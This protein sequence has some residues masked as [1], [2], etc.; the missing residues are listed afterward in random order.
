[1]H[2]PTPLMLQIQPGDA[3]PLGRQIVDGVRRQIAAGELPVG[4]QLPSV[5]V[6]AQQLLINPNTVAKAYA[7][8]CSEGWL[9]SQPGLGLFVAAPR[10]RLS[11]AEQLR[12]LDA[13]CNQFVDEVLGLDFTAEE[14]CERL[15]GE[16]QGYQKR[17]QA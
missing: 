9:E 10:E 7:E 12:R 2:R 1:M 17:K 11:P 3:R 16:L 13:A 8:L 5:R 14:V 6:L 4:A 15:Y